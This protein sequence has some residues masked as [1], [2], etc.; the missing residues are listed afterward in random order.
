MKKITKK[1]YQFSTKV[2]Y[3]AKNNNMTIKKRDDENWNTQEWKKL[4]KSTKVKTTHFKTAWIY[5]MAKHTS[6]QIKTYI[7]SSMY[8]S[9]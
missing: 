8:L 5:L 3:I 1:K 2:N 6:L 4:V 9:L 7:Y